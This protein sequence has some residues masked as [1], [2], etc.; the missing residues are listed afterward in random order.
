MSYVLFVRRC[1]CGVMSNSLS[2]YWDSHLT[3]EKTEERE[4]WEA[5]GHTV[6]KCRSLAS[7]HDLSPMRLTPCHM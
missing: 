5:T 3:D 6:S 4:V 7:S 2:S 1:L